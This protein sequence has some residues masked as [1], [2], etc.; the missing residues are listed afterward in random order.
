MKLYSPLQELKYTTVN[1][2]TSIAGLGATYT[3]GGT[4][5]LYR[6]IF[7]QVDAGAGMGIGNN[8]SNTFRFDRRPGCPHSRDVPNM[9]VLAV[10]FPGAEPGEFSFVG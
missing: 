6:E 7:R 9:A 10:N 3:F 5:P 8:S 1:S 4:F 2:S